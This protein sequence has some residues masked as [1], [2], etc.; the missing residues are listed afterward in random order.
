V[1]VVLDSNVLVAAL[2]TRGACA[3]LFARVLA[4]H[5]YA[6]DD[7][8]Q[9]EVVRVLRDKFRLPQERLARV[10]AL[11]EGTAMRVVAPALDGPACR[12]TDDDRVLALAIAFPADVL[13]SGDEDL[14]A[15]HPWRGIPIVRPRDFW[16]LDRAAGG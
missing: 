10:V 14:L 11:L 13:V 16:P 7:N 3:E 4:A 8:L 9:G 2:A 5:E 6:L 15:L 1:K 12:D